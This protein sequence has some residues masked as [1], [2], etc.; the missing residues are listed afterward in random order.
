M[1]KIIVKYRDYSLNEDVGQVF[2][3][4]ADVRKEAYDK[5]TGDYV[6]DYGLSRGSYNGI[7][8]NEK[9]QKIVSE[10]THA[11]FLDPKSLS[12]EVKEAKKKLEDAIFSFYKEPTLL[13][14]VP[15]LTNVNIYVTIDPQYQT[16]WTNCLDT[17]WFNPFF[18]NTLSKECLAGIVLHEMY[19]IRWDHS[20]RAQQ[21][22]RKQ[23][24]HLIWN[25]A[26][27]FALNFAI[28]LEDSY[29]TNMPN[30][31]LELPDT[32]CIS[33]YFS[34]QSADQIFDILFAKMKKGAKPPQGPKGPPQGPGTPTDGE[35][36]GEEI[37]FGDL[38]DDVK[39]QIQR[40]MKEQ[41]NKD[42]DSNKKD[43]SKDKSTP[44]KNSIQKQEE[45]DD[46]AKKLEEKM[47]QLKDR[48]EKNKQDAKNKQNGNSKPSDENTEDD[49]SGSGD[50]NKE[51]NKF[52]P[53]DIVEDLN[54]DRFTVEVV[55]DLV[56]V[57]RIK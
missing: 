42:F 36:E 2:D 33:S 37:D 23:E 16:A 48:V 20:K 46:Y 35:G 3:P 54:G 22:V 14:W 21:D 41:K 50:T 55:D 8:D 13:R 4:Y 15:L 12:E 47:K 19:H 49:D 57:R 1:K 18:I 31:K 43:P 9:L 39:K 29:K 56:T 40:E 6:K 38:P 28:T 24:N 5:S 52:K 26:A 11:G 34:Y 45:L 27:D 51:M 30:Y 32:A 53:G 10:K 17:I 25:M 44:V 7:T